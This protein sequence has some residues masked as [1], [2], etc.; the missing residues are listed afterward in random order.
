MNVQEKLKATEKCQQHPQVLRSCPAGRSCLSNRRELTILMPETSRQSR[1]MGKRTIIR[2]R[3]RMLS[4]IAD[5]PTRE[6]PI[7]PALNAY[8]VRPV[9]PDHD[10]KISYLRLYACFIHSTVAQLHADAGCCTDLV[11]SVLATVY[12]C[13][14]ALSS[15]TTKICRRLYSSFITKSVRFCFLA[16]CKLSLRAS[17]LAAHSEQQL[18]RQSIGHCGQYQ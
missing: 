13:H 5:L 8:H 16:V 3:S 1:S 2:T 12:S 4:S 6:K 11:C 17:R 14:Y 10:I 18:A 9:G 7:G 15:T